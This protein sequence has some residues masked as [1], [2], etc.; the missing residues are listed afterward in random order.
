MKEKKLI[1]RLKEIQ[2]NHLFIPEYVE[3]YTLINTGNRHDTNHYDLKLIDEHH[4]E[5]MIRKKMRGDNSIDVFV[6]LQTKNQK[7]IN[8][9]RVYTTQE[10]PLK[11]Y[12]MKSE[13]DWIFAFEGVMVST[14][15]ETVKLAFKIHFTSNEPIEDLINDIVLTKIN[16]H[17]LKHP[18]DQEMINE[19]EMTEIVSYQQTGRVEGKIQ[20]EDKT[21]TLNTTGIRHHKFGKSSYQR[22][23]RVLQTMI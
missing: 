8:K 19:Q 17:I 7:Y 6:M 5:L 3:N 15:K 12:C 14:D 21:I 13:K 22:L 11:I 2:E 18:I 4:N 16:K 23:F 10:D 1:K 9:K 20:I